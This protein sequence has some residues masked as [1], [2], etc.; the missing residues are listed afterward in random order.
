MCIH[1]RPVEIEHDKYLLIDILSKCF[2]DD[3]NNIREEY[4]ESLKQ[5]N[6]TIYF[7]TIE[8]HVIGTFE[9]VRINGSKDC[10][11]NSFCILPNYRRQGFAERALNK[12]LLEYADRLI[13]SSDTKMSKNLYSKYPDKIIYPQSNHCAII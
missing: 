1:F 5:P 11:F 6:L 2:L 8:G 13:I 9:L 3:F 7:I 12:I 10:R 4:I